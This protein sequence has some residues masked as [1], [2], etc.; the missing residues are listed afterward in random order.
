MLVFAEPCI[1][2]VSFSALFPKKNYVMGKAG[3]SFHFLAGRTFFFLRNAKNILIR[4]VGRV[5]MIEW[6]NTSEQQ[7]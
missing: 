3:S 7:T 6:K 5:N 2:P 4:Q 1:K